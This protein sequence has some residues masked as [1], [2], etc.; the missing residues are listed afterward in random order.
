M[1]GH[2]AVVSRE[3]ICFRQA[4]RREVRPQITVYD[5]DIT[6]RPKV[7]TFKFVSVH[8][9]KRLLDIAQLVG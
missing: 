4:L 1:T 7:V 9:A 3:Q 2:T 5:V 6:E 8:M